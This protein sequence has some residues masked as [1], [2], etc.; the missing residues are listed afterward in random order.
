MHA[1]PDLDGGDELLPAQVETHGRH[2]G[3]VEPLAGVG[4]GHRGQPGHLAL[5][6]DLR[7]GGE[8]ALVSE[9]DL[10]AELPL[11]EALEGGLGDG[12]HFAEV[13]IDIRPFQNRSYLDCS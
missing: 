11:G 2:G 10:E 1:Q 3:A 9:V 13:A 4:E 8:E 12:L 7:V 5:A 6:R